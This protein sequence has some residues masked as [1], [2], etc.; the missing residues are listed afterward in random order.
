LAVRHVAMQSPLQSVYGATSRCSSAAVADT[1][2]KVSM[3]HRAAHLQLSARHVRIQA[4]IYRTAG[5]Q[6]RNPNGTSK[7]V[8]SNIKYSHYH[9]WIYA[10]FLAIDACFR[11]KLKDRG[12]DDARLGSGWSYFVNNEEYHAHLASASNAA[13]VCQHSLLI[14]KY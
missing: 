6:N 8:H 7:S 5:K 2:P 13:S 10:L 1:F 12:I 14:P 9:R 4:R 11:L 3:Q